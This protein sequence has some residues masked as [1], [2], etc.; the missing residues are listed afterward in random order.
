MATTSTVNV[1]TDKDTGFD[2]RPIV[3]EFSP[4]G[5]FLSLDVGDVL[6]DGAVHPRASVFLTEERA[7]ALLEVISAYFRKGE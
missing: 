1:H 4:G 6:T 2:L 7:E 3:S 5:F